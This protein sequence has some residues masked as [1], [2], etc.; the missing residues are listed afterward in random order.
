MFTDKGGT[1]HTGI[2]SD[3]E[4]YPGFYRGESTLR[5]I[6]G[7]TLNP[8][9]P[10]PLPTLVNDKFLPQVQ[11]CDSKAAHYYAEVGLLLLSHVMLVVMW[12]L[13][14]YAVSNSSQAT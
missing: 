9:P 8:P 10:P 14:I 13:C 1:G 7:G 4:E 12:R 6:P 2:V 3:R 5:F 11:D